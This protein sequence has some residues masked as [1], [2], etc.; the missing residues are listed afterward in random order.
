V[1]LVHPELRAMGQPAER[2]IN[3]PS[4]YQKGSLLPKSGLPKNGLRIGRSSGDMIQPD[5]RI[6]R[7]CKWE[8][9]G[10]IRDYPTRRLAQRAL[11]DGVERLVGFVGGFDNALDL[12]QLGKH[13]P[14]KR[15]V[16]NVTRRPDTPPHHAKRRH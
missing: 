7:P 6:R 2:G 3:G 1:F 9:L 11:E 14:V 8:V 5:G 13:K 10:T 16:G 12:L 4:R 15:I